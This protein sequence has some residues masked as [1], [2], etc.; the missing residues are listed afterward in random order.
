L[1]IW[2]KTIRRIAVALSISTSGNHCFILSHREIPF[3]DVVLR[4]PG[5]PI[6]TGIPDDSGCRMQNILPAVRIRT[7]HL[8]KKLKNKEE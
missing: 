2:P 4:I 8:K 1:S 5:K 6:F 3:R 7:V